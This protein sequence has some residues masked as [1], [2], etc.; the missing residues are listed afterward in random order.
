[1]WA[2]ATLWT[3]DLEIMSFVVFVVVI[4][5]TGWP[6]PL[7]RSG[8]SGNQGVLVLG[9]I[10]FEQQFPKTCDLCQR[11]IPYTST[12]R[13]CIRIFRSTR[14]RDCK[15]RK[16]DLH[17]IFRHFANSDFCICKIRKLAFAKT[18][19]HPFQHVEAI[20]CIFWFRVYAESQTIKKRRTML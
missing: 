7:A 11:A 20:G 2:N 19:S 17:N 1:M 18:W 6:R 9:N 5:N 14:N 10:S 16:R 4:V 8:T 3:T 15:F 12:W 13:S